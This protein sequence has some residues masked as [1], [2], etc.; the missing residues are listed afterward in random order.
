MPSPVAPPPIALL[1][2]F[3]QSDPFVGI[4]K[5]V[6]LA[7]FPEAKVVDLTHHIPPQ[8]VRMGAY[9]LMV[10]APY[11]PQDSI[12]VCV[13]DPGVGSE[14]RIIYART[15]THQFLAP[16]NGLLSWVERRRPFV[17]VRQVTNRTLA[18]A[19]LSST[20]HGRDVF[21]PVAAE[22]S[23]GLSSKELGPEIAEIKRIPFPEPVRTGGKV[24]GAVLAVDRFGNV[25]TNLTTAD[26]KAT[27]S[28]HFKNHDLGELKSHYT[29]VE[30]G[31]PLSLLGSF[32][33]VELA[34]RNGSFSKSFGASIGDVVEGVDA[35][36]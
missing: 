12:F 21:A 34:V 35:A 10:S 4:M 9:T 3:G 15:K 8:D 28:F 29:T 6:M 32:G 23:R 36:A 7:R 5:G 14:R 25:I 31:K 33:F 11:F 1:T 2:D 16:D 22:L 13:V 24:S 26:L 19:N 18:L 27:A 20:F 17:E 30:P